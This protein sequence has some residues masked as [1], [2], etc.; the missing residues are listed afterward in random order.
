M[1]G[2]PNIVV[3]KFDWENYIY[4]CVLRAQ[5]MKDNTD[6]DEDRDRYYGLIVKNVDV[7]NYIIKY[8]I[9][10]NNKFLINVMDIID[11]RGVLYGVFEV[12]L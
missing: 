9:F 5:Y 6:C 3:K 1:K 11:D 4:K 12:L 7:Y 10:R 2:F 8:E